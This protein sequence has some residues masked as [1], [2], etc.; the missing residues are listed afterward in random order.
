[1]RY[2]I[3][4][5]FLIGSY[6]FANDVKEIKKMLIKHY[7]S[8]NSARWSEVVSDFYSKGTING[9]SN[10]DFWYNRQST[11]KAFTKDMS[12]GDKYNFTPRYINVE[13]LETSPK[14]PKI[15]VAYF[16]LTGSYTIGGVTKHD[17]RTRVSSLLI[18]ENGKWKIRL[19]D[20]TPLHSGSGIPN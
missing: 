15:A 9:D 1:M 7:N 16:Y 2:P 8:M 11:E 4:L 17:Y 18:T 12:T 19:S 6:L 20:F 3:I 5:F 13:I 10:G 14:F